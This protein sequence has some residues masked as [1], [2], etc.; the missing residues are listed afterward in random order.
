VGF[1]FIFDLNR[2]RGPPLS[3]GFRE[4]VRDARSRLQLFNYE[5]L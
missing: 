3:D 2:R 4:T 1:S 5:K